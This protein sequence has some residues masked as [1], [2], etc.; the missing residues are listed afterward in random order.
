M[1][2]FRGNRDVQADSS[3]DICPLSTLNPNQAIKPALAVCA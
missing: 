2:H 3:S 1:Q